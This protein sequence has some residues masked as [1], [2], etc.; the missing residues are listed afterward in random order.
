MEICF[1]RKKFEVMH[2][3]RKSLLFSSAASVIMVGHPRQS[4]GCLPSV[5]GSSHPSITRLAAFKMISIPSSNFTTNVSSYLTCKTTP[6]FPFIALDFSSALPL[7]STRKLY[8][9]VSKSTAHL[10]TTTSHSLQA[11]AFK[12]SCHHDASCSKQHS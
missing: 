5:F 6:D 4:S 2:F 1:H 11:A 8:P 3:V 9:P 12:T 7:T 10:H